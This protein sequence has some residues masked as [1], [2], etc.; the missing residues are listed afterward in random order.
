[1]RFEG[2]GTQV[3]ELQVVI[4]TAATCIILTLL[5]ASGSRGQAKTEAEWGIAPR[6][7]AATSPSVIKA[8]AIPML[9]SIVFAVALFFVFSATHTTGIGIYSWALYRGVVFGA[10]SAWVARN[11]AGA[12]IARVYNTATSVAVPVQSSAA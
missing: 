4:D 5:M 2:A 11:V 12:A 9:A 1:V 6:A 10:Y 3:P 8:F 7:A